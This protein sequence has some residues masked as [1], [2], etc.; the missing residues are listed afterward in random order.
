MKK[1]WKSTDGALPL[2][3]Y[4]SSESTVA[5]SACLSLSRLA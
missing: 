5:Q 2:R 1:S 3:G 4:V